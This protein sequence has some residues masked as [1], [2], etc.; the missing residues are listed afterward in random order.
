MSTEV[1]TKQAQWQK[2]FGYILGNQAAWIADI[3]LKAGLFRAVADVGEEGITEE[4]LAQRL[5]YK[6]R[7]VQVWCRGAYAFE[8]LDWEE[9]SGYR[10]APHME[11]LLLDPADPQFLG[12]ASNSTPPFTR[13]IG[14]SLSTCVQVGYGLA[15]TT[16]PSCSRRSRTPRSPT[17]SC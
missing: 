16:T 2:L 6:L 15:A 14:L 10:L 8:L 7:Y 12:G 4:A 3:G 5:D 1:S 17:A 11:S 13:T 9:R